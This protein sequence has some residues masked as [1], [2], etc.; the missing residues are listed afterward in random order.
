[1]RLALER[2]GTEGGE[3]GRRRRNGLSLLRPRE[4]RSG[5]AQG[6]EGSRGLGARVDR[7]AEEAE[8]RHLPPDHRADR[9]PGVHADADRQLHAVDVY[10]PV[11]SGG[12]G[13]GRARSSGGSTRECVSQPPSSS[14]S[15][16]LSPP[17]PAK[18]AIGT[19]LAIAFAAFG[20]RTVRSC[21]SP[22]R[23]AAQGLRARRSGARGLQPSCRRPLEVGEKGGGDRSANCSEMAPVSPWLGGFLS[24]AGLYCRCSAG[25]ARCAHRSSPPCSTA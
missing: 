11:G 1:M 9:R 7:V 15:L 24:H 5:R 8:P 3:R 22:P 17:A 2:G 4:S 20:P 18:Q 12:D 10:P 6:S 23:S 13:S 16:S 19:G 25:C 14:D 21:A